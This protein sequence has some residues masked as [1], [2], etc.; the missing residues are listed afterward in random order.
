MD[1]LN[2]A[3]LKSPGTAGEIFAGQLR[4]GR[5]VRMN[6]TGES[7]RPLMK[8]GD[9]VI[10]NPIKFEDTN[11]QDIVVY[12]RDPRQGFTMHRLIKKGRD[13][14]DREYLV[15]KGDANRYGDV[16]PVYPDNLYGRVT[17]IERTDGRV[18]NLESK[19][20]RLQAYLIARR[21]RCLSIL[22]AV[23]EA[24]HLVPVKLID[25][26]RNITRPPSHK[27]TNY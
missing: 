22:R 8:R 27:D 11:V 24:P 7:M 9:I 4:K 5:R 20:R 3:S 16:L 2:T 15:T 1:N 13:S 14:E 6:T 18:V 17:L 26:I 23:L 25:K 10:I 19:Y 12:S 21:S